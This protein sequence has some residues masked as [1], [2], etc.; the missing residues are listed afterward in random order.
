[1]AVLERY[2]ISITLE[3]SGGTDSLYQESQ[4]GHPQK[5]I[6]RLVHSSNSSSFQLIEF[7]NSG[8]LGDP[9]DDKKEEKHWRTF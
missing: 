5:Y 4:R 9:E 8:R 6:Q 2:L 1:M 3:P 7:N